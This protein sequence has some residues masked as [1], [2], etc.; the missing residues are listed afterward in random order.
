MTASLSN[1][2]GASSSDRLTSDPALTG[3]GD[4][5]AVVHFTVDGQAIASTVTADAGGNWSFT[6]S[7]LADGQHTIVASE[8]NAAGATSSASLTFALDR[9]APEGAII[10]IAA[11]N[12]QAT[13]T[14]SSGSA[15]DQ[16]SI[17]D[18]L[19]R[20]GFATTGSNGAWSFTAAAAPDVAH[21]YSI[22]LTDLAGNNGTGGG[23][24]L[25]GRTGAEFA[26]RQRRQ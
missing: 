1:D 21:N 25:L 6:P 14:G 10:E 7:G 26:D 5:N 8:T 16:I 12:G 15:G 18:G 9:T 4:D 24:G 13:L 11:A 20:L 2:T 3:T 19:T 23:R 22:S 17:Y